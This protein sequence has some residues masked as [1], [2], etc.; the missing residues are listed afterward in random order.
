[1]AIVW[2]THFTFG[3]FFKEFVEEFGW[4][5]AVTSM[6]FSLAFITSGLMSVLMGGL[7][8]RIGPRKVII[9]S[10][11]VLGLGF[12]LMSKVTNAWQL[13]LVY[14]VI[15]GIGFSG[16]FVPL[17]STGA[18]WFFKRRNVM[19]GIIVS[20]SGL[21]Q[22]LMP[23]LAVQLID[24]FGWRT[25]YAI[26]GTAIFLFLVTTAQFLK[27]D[28]AQMG[29]LPYGL[30]H[31]SKPDSTVESKGLSVEEALRTRQLWIVFILFWCLAFLLQTVNVHIVSY[32]IDLG[33][34]VIAAA[35]VLATIGG[36]S[37]IGRILG[38]ISAD[39]I[40]NKKIYVIGFVVM[41]LSLFFLALVTKVWLLYMFAIVF[42]IA[43]GGCVT[44]ESPLVASL[45]GLRSHGLILG[46]TMIGFTIGASLGPIV[47]GHIFDI[48]GSYQVAFLI[49]AAIGVVGLL[50]AAILKPRKGK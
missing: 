47:S 29:L 43:L 20:G 2:G 26:F 46:I 42:G 40:G 21:G 9:L 24:A 14:G 38:G 31:H 15:I 10:G 39:K 34:T 45:F 35:S 19:T 41:S 5:R 28:P 4:T 50:L 49:C 22:L 13:F 27:Q 12:F 3:V 36:V 30:N 11:F 18:K 7:T 17:A 37:I 44:S 48:T 23:L 6:P 25:S 16:T 1:M 32:S 8:D 33:I